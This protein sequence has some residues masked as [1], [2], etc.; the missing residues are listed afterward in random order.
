MGLAGRRA[1]RRLHWTSFLT[2]LT[3]SSWFTIRISKIGDTGCCAKG[4][5]SAAP[6]LKIHFSDC[7]LI[8][9]CQ[10]LICTG[11]DAGT[12]SLEYTLW[13]S[14]FYCIVEAGRKVRGRMLLVLPLATLAQVCV[15][16]MTGGIIAAAAQLSAT[17]PSRGLGLLPPST[18]ALPGR[19]GPAGSTL[20]INKCGCTDIAQKLY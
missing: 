2:S 9:D 15:S 8:D 18:P 5:A 11:S 3:S 14:G 1:E 10:K 6:C 17:A 20:F 12:K 16:M 7:R 13:R 4:Y 19:Q